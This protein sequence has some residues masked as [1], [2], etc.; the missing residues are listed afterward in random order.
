MN[1]DLGKVAKKS[2]AAVAELIRRYIATGLASEMNTENRQ[3]E[4]AV[5]GPR[6]KSEEG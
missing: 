3:Y 4:V 2:G 1:E 6:S 5:G